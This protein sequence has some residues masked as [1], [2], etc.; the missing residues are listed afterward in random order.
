MEEKKRIYT[1]NEI[2]NFYYEN[3]FKRF[4][5][6]I[7]NGLFITPENVLP[8]FDLICP[9]CKT[10][11]LKRFRSDT[12]IHYYKHEKLPINLETGRFC[13]YYNSE[14]NFKKDKSQNNEEKKLSKIHSEA[15][16]LIYSH[17][18]N[19]NDIIVEKICDFNYDCCEIKETKIIK[20]DEGDNIKK[21]HHFKWNG[22]NYFA[23]LAILGKNKDIKI[24]IEVCH[25]HKT[26]ESKRPDCIYWCELRSFQIIRNLS[27]CKT[28][29]DNNFVCLRKLKCNT[30]IDENKKKQ[31]EDDEIY[32]ELQ[33]I[34]EIA[35]IEENEEYIKKLKIE[36][37]LKKQQNLIKEQ[38][39]AKLLAKRN[40]ICKCCNLQITNHHFKWLYIQNI[41]TNVVICYD[42]YIDYNIHYVSSNFRKLFPTSYYKE[43]RKLLKLKKIEYQYD[44]I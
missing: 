23:D 29:K 11:V 40:L 38:E 36:E 8:D 28:N 33:R 22:N 13:D 1:D 2:K 42:C 32:Q 3:V 5:Q 19:K 27:Y 6:N 14:I 9:K 7:Q 35:Q 25:T 41:K 10:P 4:A 24:I 21:E 17:L 43:Y 44:N 34:L 15:I 18:N 16:E 37:K 30:C 39:S 26:D 12:N 31:T 20:L